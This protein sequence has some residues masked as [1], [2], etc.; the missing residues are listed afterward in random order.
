[1]PLQDIIVSKIN[2]FCGKKIFISTLKEIK[3]S[4]NKREQDVLDYT[5]I[6]YTLLYNITIDYEEDVVKYHQIRKELLDLL[7]KKSK[8]F[9]NQHKDFLVFFIDII[10][11]GDE[12]INGLKRMIS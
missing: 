6:Y 10:N 1:M 3:Y 5:I 9:N 2:D 4:C 11:F 8:D 12:Y 7:V